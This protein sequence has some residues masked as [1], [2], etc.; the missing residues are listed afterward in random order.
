MRFTD[1]S[2]MAVVVFAVLL[3]HS[4]LSA[5]VV[6]DNT[7][8]VYSVMMTTEVGDTVTLAGNARNINKFSVGIFCRRD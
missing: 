7:P 2:M 4:L 8:D 6:Y 5:E 3:F 1:K